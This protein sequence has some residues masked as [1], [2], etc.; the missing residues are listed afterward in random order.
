VP[1]RATCDQFRATP[2]IDQS[3]ATTLGTDI[4]IVLCANPSTGF[5]WE[6]PQI[7]DAAVIRL[8]DH[9]YQAPDGASSP[10]VGAAGSEILTVHALAA[11][12]T[13]LSTRYS[14]P[15]DGGTKG[16]WTYRLSVTVR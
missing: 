2:T 3:I 10:I 1:L 9:G 13:T 7:A 12:S 6:E 15:W 4:T 14:Q 16:E 8:V 11:G 5:A